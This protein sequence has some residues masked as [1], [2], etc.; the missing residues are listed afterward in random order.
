M[1]TV[2]FTKAE[3]TRLKIIQSAIW[4]F[5]H[6]GISD[7]SFQAVASRAKLSQ[8]AIFHYFKDKSELISAC[9][10]VIT[11]ANHQRVSDLVSPKEDSVKQ[12]MSHMT[13]NLQ[14]GLESPEQGRLLLLIY[15]LS[16]FDSEFNRIYGELL[17]KARQRI[18]VYLYAAKRESRLRE[19][20]VDIEELAKAFHDLLVGTFV[21]T[22]SVDSHS[23][24][25]KATL[26]KSI[27]GRWS[28]FF[29]LTFS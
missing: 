22:L 24:K 28:H 5:A 7:G 23:K 11:A 1:K 20:T 9:V 27:Q 13:A 15:H 10:E 6:K 18:E 3:Q 25:S 8:S 21:N 16:C 17:E 19:T 26:M 12:L 14:W 2:P 4:I 29:Q